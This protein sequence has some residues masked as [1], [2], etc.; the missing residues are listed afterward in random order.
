MADDKKFTEDAYEQTLIA[1]FRDELGYKYECGYEVERDYKEPFYRADLEA[2]MRRLNPDLPAAALDDGIKKLTTINEGTLEQNNEKFTKWMQDGLE[3]QVKLNGEERTV[4]MQL[5]DYEHPQRNLFKVVNQ[6]RVED[7]K[8]KRCDMVV[9]VNG[10]PLVVVELKSA[11]AEDATIDEAYKQIK[12]YQQSIQSLFNY[13]AFNVISDMSETKAGTITAKQER[14]MEWKSI[15]GENVSTL[16]ADY[17]TFFIGMFQQQRLL[18]ILKNY[19]CFEHKEGKISKILAAYH[20]YFAVGKVMVRTK[21][22]VGG[23]GKIGVFWQT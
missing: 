14:Y 23:D 10:L 3:V 13:N 21:A 8:N 20:Q 7:Y 9:M 16:V 12:N 4:L 15:D 18:D 17:R 2:S 5:I 6:W 19:I 22:A 1:L 11:T